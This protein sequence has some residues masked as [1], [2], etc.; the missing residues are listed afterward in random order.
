M[1]RYIVEVHTTQIPNR[2]TVFSYY[3]RDLTTGRIVR[4]LQ[5]QDKATALRDSLE[6][7][8]ES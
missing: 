2:P 7:G 4:I 1:A 6:E 8:S 3:V 5:D